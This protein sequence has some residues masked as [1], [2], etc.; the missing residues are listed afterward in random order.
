MRIVYLNGDYVPKSA[1]KVSVFDRGLLFS[2]AVYEVIS[3]ING[4]LIDME[5]HV[6]RL[7][8]SL[9]EL[10]IN[11]FAD[12][13]ASHGHWWPKMACRKGWSICRCRAA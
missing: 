3:V 8:R 2:D 10:S 13:S 4:H 9:G 1:A 6:T 7:E 5:R 12:W 11:A